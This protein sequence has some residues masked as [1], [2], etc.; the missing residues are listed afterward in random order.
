MKWFFSDNDG[1]QE[2]GYHDAGVE[3]FK[4]DFYSYLA[5]ELIQNSLDAR[6]DP[7]KP[8]V[9][10]FHA[11]DIPRSEIPEVD[12]LANAI[13]RCAEYWA[14][15]KKA[16]QFFDKAYALLKEDT[17]SALRIGDYNTTG[18]EGSDTERGKNWYNLVRCSGSSSKGGG[19]GGSFGI[20]K[21]APF[22]A[23][24]LRTIFYSTKT[25]DKKVAFQG[26]AKLATHANFN[27]GLAQATGYL[28]ETKGSAVREFDD[29]P[30]RF[31]RSQAGTDIVI[32]G[33]RTDQEWKKELVFSVLENFWPAIHFSDLEVQIDDLKISKENLRALL[34][35]HAGREGFSA[36]LYFRAY[37]NHPPVDFHKDLPILGK[38][39][40]Y[41]LEGD[42][43]L[44]KRVAM[45]R[46]TG[47]VIY[48]KAFRFPLPFCGVFICKNEKGNKIL[49]D[50]EPPRHDQWDANH[51]EKGEN[52]R[53][54][55]EFLSFIRECIKTLSPAEDSK[56][57]NIPGLS[58]F[59]PDDQESMEHAFDEK[60]TEIDQPQESADR[61]PKPQ[62]LVG[63]KIDPK[64]KSLQPNSTMT[65]TGTE[66]TEQPG[67]DGQDN[68][69]I[70]GK[71]T[72]LPGQGTKI[73]AE[74]GGPGGK[75][76]KESVPISYR[77]F[78]TNLSS[79]AYVAVVTS[80]DKKDAKAILR[81]NEVGDDAV[82]TGIEIR[83]ASILGGELLSVKNNAIGPI[84]L[85]PGCPVRLEIVLK[86]PTRVAMEVE[87]HEAD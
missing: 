64:R 6:H 41:L 62:Q 33:F 82:R 12:S 72:L 34:D 81:I 74:V 2:S 86:D 85:H 21:N 4:G 16:L 50:M 53:T 26:V 47:M 76:G 31:L 43:E 63:R 11:E 79:G 27:G 37:T 39:S 87:A 68:G 40:L 83:Q 25:I 14:N 51:P 84:A 17:I 28:G 67:E 60:S 35:D 77:T 75:G 36:H 66:L 9:V 65:G 46:G 49:R 45:I 57:I 58:R 1:G 20:G 44:P 56:I 30:P 69:P 23:S 48:Q 19:E 80:A 71:N 7:N 13:K 32:L 3:T 5:R 54:E 15:D 22:V 8:V 73:K 61:R 38:T 42:P 24:L 59:L 29:I 55:S 70:H 18:V 78:V 52:K 10:R